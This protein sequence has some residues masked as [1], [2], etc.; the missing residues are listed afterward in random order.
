MVASTQ[1]SGV[2]QSELAM[3][4]ALFRQQKNLLDTYSF[5]IATQSRVQRNVK[6]LTSISKDA[7]TRGVAGVDD[8][9]ATHTEIGHGSY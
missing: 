2:P 4:T 6:Q 9:E 5:V 3:V 1:T 7:T 8:D